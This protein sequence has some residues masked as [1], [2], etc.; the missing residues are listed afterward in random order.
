MAV[1]PQEDKYDVGSGERFDDLVGLIEHF[2]S[3]PMIETSGDVLRLLQPVSGTGLRAHDIDQKI[4][5]MEK[6]QK[7]ENKGGYDGEFLSLNLAEEMNLFSMEEGEKAENIAKNRYRNV[8]P[9]D[10]TRVILR[11]IGD[12]PPE[13]DY[14]NANYIRSNNVFEPSA[15][16]SNETLNSVQ[17]LAAQNDCIK[18]PQLVTKSLSDEALR[19]IKKCMKLD[20]INGNLRLSTVKDKTYIATQG[21]LASTVN[22]F[23]HMIWQDDVR[24]IAMITK[25]TE[26]GKKKCD[27]YWPLAGRE[28]RYHKFLV[29]SVS[30]TLYEDYVLRELEVTDDSN[31]RRSVYQYQFTAWPDHGTP[32]EP[33]GVLAFL[34]DIN[35]RMH[36]S[37]LNS[38]P[39][40]QNVLCVHCSAGVGRTGTFI[41]LDMLIDQI[42]M[43]GF[44]CDIDVHSTVKAVRTQRRG[45]VQN[46]AQYRFIYLA[47]QSY[48]D[49]KDLKLRKKV[50]PSDG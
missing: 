40:E 21:C 43:F 31:T 10:E 23:W 25:E 11:K 29:K 37:T 27:R 35:T 13:A 2:R 28:E 17:P 47:L 3:Y 20:K 12:V 44:N 45:M 9:Y 50:Y 6:F 14:V 19:E 18:S 42:K 34:D 41:V 38:N 15:L 1:D 4:M 5:E 46:K 26:R 48:V 36:Q 22:D 24:V 49:K 8:L 32:N 7:P 33:D 30:E 39:P 16:S